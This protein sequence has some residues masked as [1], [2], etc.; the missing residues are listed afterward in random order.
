MESET[1]DNIKSTLQRE[2]ASLQRTRDELRLQASLARADL[3]SEWQRLETRFGLLQEEFSRLGAHSLAAAREVEARVGTL[4]EEL[5]AGYE[6]IRR[7]P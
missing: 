4:I 3:H 6:R 7:A 1:L 5:K 2:L